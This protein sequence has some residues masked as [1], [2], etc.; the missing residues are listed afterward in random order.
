[1]ENSFENLNAIEEGIQILLM[2][3]RYF[4]K[5]VTEFKKWLPYNIV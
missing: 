2:F 4:Q 3:Q 5:Q 1:M